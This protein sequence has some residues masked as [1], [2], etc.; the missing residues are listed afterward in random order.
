[1]DRK[2]L[3]IGGGIAAVAVVGFIVMKSKSGTNTSSQSNAAQPADSGFFTGLSPISGGISSDSGLGGG[4]GGA[5]TDPAN[6][7][8]SPVGGGFDIASLL[9]GLFKSQADTSSLQIRTG[10]NVS[11]AAVLAG[12]NFGAYGGSGTIIHNADGTTLNVNPGGDPYDA[13]VNTAYKSTLNRA[14]DIGGQAFFKNQLTHGV[15]YDDVVKQML[16]S[17]EYLAAHPKPVVVS[18]PNPYTG[19]PTVTTTSTVTN[20]DG[21]TTVTMGKKQS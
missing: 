16:N 18:Q 3:M 11:E 2:I 5:I 10:A 17:P 9:S 12:I 21:T 4:G 8:S 1:M 20:A 13:L 14:P 6:S 15:S 7:G 19:T